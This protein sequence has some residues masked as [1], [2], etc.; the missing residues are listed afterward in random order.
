MRCTRMVV[1]ERIWSGGEGFRSPGR[2]TQ[3]RKLKGC[4]LYARSREAVERLAQSLILACFVAVVD[5]AAWARPETV[6]PLLD[7]E[8]FLREPEFT[9]VQLSPDGR[10]LAFFKSQGG[11]KNLW[12]QRTD[13]PFSAP[14][15]VTAVRDQPPETCYWSQDSR[16]L[17]FTRDAS[18]NGKPDLFTVSVDSIERADGAPTARNLTGGLGTP[19]RVVAVPQAASGLVYVALSEGN[20]PGQDLY[21]IAIT[22]GDRR[23]LRTN[24]LAARD[25]VFDLTGELRLAIRTG[26]YGEFELL[27]LDAAGA[28]PIYRCIWS[29]TCTPLQFDPDGRHLYLASNH[30]EGVD[31]VRLISLDVRTGQEQDVASDPAQQVDLDTTVFSPSTHR[32]AATVYDG[33]AGVR[34][35]WQDPG[36]QADFRRL[37]RRLPG[38][39]LRLQPAAA[40]PDWL[41]FASSDREPG[42]AYL[43]DLHRGTLTLQY[44]SIPD[45]PRDALARMI[46]IRYPSADGLSIPA[47]LTLPR[48]LAPKSLPLLVLPH[49]GPWNVRDQWGYSGF[50]QLFANR[51]FAVLQPNFRGSAGFGKRF[52]KAGDRQWGDRMQ[53][54][55]TAGV[56]RLVESRLADPKRVAIFGMS[57]GGYAALAGAAFTPGLYAA[58]VDMAGPSDLTLLFDS[59]V[60][61]SARVLFVQSVGNPSTPEGRMQLV[62]QSPINSVERIKA[63]VLMIQGARDPA[64][65]QAQSDRMAAALHERQARVTYLLAQDEAHVLGPGRAWADRLNNLAVFAE[66]EALLGQAVGVAYE[67]DMPPEVSQRLKELTVPVH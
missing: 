15:P 11:V 3:Y 44:R 4:C 62:R 24:D 14:R 49:A 59:D 61:K 37:Q 18:D 29:E 1:G 38:K 67:R 66:I 21:S 45:V 48:G 30:G 5:T 6:V 58:A 27:R 16:Y 60:V 47:L 46:A 13:K 2:R 65:V 36:M 56:R 10:F 42:E 7:R 55:I 25:W 39:Q 8:L 9:A 20:R 31:L 26:Q 57:Y 53:D 19:A 64:S 51:G 23:L 63:P 17:L 43:F 32:P 33:D 50:A 54:D 41:V 12:I 34:Y 22:T 40:G 35:A 28:T 52:L